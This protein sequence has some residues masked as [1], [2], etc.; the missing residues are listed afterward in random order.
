[1]QQGLVK[2]A[3]WAVALLVSALTVAAIGPSGLFAT[4]SLSAPTP[5]LQQELSPD[6]AYPVHGYLRRA[7]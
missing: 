3:I 4:E 1:M 5:L 7:A 2:T 6:Q